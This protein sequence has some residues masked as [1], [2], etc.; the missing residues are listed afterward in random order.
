MDF[1]KSD[2]AT[3]PGVEFQAKHSEIRYHFY[4][5]CMNC[6]SFSVTEV[7]DFLL[8]ELE[9]LGYRLNKEAVYVDDK[10]IKGEYK[11]LIGFKFD[12]IAVKCFDNL[13]KMNLPFMFRK[14]YSRTFQAFLEKYEHVVRKI[15]YPIDPSMAP[16][17]KIR[18]EHGNPSYLISEDYV[19]SYSQRSMER[20]ISPSPRRNDMRPGYKKYNDRE[21]PRMQGRSRQDYTPSRSRSVERR[22]IGGRSFD[23]RS[24]PRNGREESYPRQS[25][26]REENTHKGIC[27]SYILEARYSEV[28]R[29]LADECVCYL[30]GLPIDVTGDDINEE[31]SHRQIHKPIKVEKLNKSKNKV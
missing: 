16:N 25:I 18:R 15:A 24:P 9:K 7:K 23:R 17:Q 13:E 4:V 31:L 14:Q 12:H 8:K 27:N 22:S 1:I 28:K 21:S 29:D 20:P 11:A 3:K 26:E 5:I 10:D 6:L 30:F 19:N 2:A